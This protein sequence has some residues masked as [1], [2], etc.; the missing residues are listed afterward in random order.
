MISGILL[1]FSCKYYNNYYYCKINTN[2]NKI[3]QCDSC[4]MYGTGIIY[5]CDNCKDYYSKDCSGCDTFNNKYYC[6]ICKDSNSSFQ[7]CYKKN[8]C[9]LDEECFNCI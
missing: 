7:Y 9:H 5:S 4:V 1:Y 2:V 6:D 3:S 8:T